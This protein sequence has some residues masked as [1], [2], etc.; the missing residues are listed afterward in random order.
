TYAGK[1][2]KSTIAE[3]PGSKVYRIEEG[4]LLY[5]DAYHTNGKWSGGQTLIYQD[6][7]NVWRMSYEG[8]C[9]DD[10]NILD[11]LK[12]VLE[13]TY[14]A[15][16][17]YGGRGFQ[18]IWQNGENQPGLVYQNYTD[19]Y[20]WDFSFFSG[21]EYINR[22]PNHIDQI[23]WHR[24]QGMLLVGQPEDGI[25][26]MTKKDPDCEFNRQRMRA[27]Q[28]YFQACVESWKRPRDLPL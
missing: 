21:R 12:L 18:Q 23:F 9:E 3:F 8:W 28:A 13:G 22:C 11:F 10:A 17:F 24:Y 16:V 6:D 26:K 14:Q 15:G 2:V 7:V 20:H 1:G 19:P 27:R 4:N 25:P 5:V